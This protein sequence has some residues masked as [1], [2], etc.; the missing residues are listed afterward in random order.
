M[1]LLLYDLSVVILGAKQYLKRPFPFESM[2]VIATECMW[3]GYLKTVWNEESLKNIH[4][5]EVYRI[6]EIVVSMYQQIAAPFPIL[7]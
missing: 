7:L 2:E 1:I 6:M 3:H 4:I 5:S